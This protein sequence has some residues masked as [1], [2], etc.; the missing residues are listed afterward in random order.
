MAEERTGLDEK[1]LTQANMP[2]IRSETEQIPVIPMQ[3]EPILVQVQEQMPMSTAPLPVPVKA[4]MPSESEELLPPG[5][6]PSSPAK[7]TTRKKCPRGKRRNKKTHRCNKKCPE[8]YKRNKTRSRCI[9]KL[10]K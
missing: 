2:P 8:G 4:P 10:K 7:K 3:S 6:S 9:K 1:I 5:P